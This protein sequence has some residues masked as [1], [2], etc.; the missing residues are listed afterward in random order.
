MKMYFVYLLK[1]VTHDQLYIGSTNDLEIRLKQHNDGKNPSTGRY[2]PWTLVYYEAYPTEK[3]S[4]LREKQ[5]K[6]HGNAKREMYKRL[7]ITDT[8]KRV[9]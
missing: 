3:I 8:R 2:K 6:Y 9:S 7:G 5:L 4:R 1:S